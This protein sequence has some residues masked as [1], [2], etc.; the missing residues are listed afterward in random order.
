MFKFERLLFCNED[1]KIKPQKGRARKKGGNKYGS[2]CKTKRS[3]YDPRGDV[4]S[5]CTGSEEKHSE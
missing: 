5:I 2:I 1:G 3:K 4:S